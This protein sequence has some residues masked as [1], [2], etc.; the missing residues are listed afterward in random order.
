[1]PNKIT[2]ILENLKTLNLSR[3]ERAVM[4]ALYIPWQLGKEYRVTQRQIAHTERWMGIHTKHEGHLPIRTTETTLR[5][6]RQ[7]IRDLRVK[8]NAPILSDRDGYYI[9]Q[10]ESQA[11]EYLGRIEKEAKSQAKAWQETYRAMQK[12]LGFQSKF[13]EE[14][15]ATVS[16]L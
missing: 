2:A 6:V 15:S 1:M 3:E 16:L 11:L 5:K 10:T 7:V 13:F 9:P 4:S 14:Q 8:Y 12:S